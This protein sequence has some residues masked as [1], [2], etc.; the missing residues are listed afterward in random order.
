MPV[1]YETKTSSEVEGGPPESTSMGCYTGYVRT[2]PGILKIVE[3]VSTCIW[4]LFHPTSLE[5]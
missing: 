1:T 3:M 5:Q 4:Y 2:I